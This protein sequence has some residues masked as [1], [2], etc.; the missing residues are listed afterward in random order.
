MNIVANH[1][2]ATAALKKI[3][4]AAVAMMIIDLPPTAVAAAVI[5]SIPIVSAIRFYQITL[6]AHVIAH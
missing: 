3:S 4:V 6:T 5:P 1:L 2:G